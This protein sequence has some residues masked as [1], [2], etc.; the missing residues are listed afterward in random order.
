MIIV[1]F[2]RCLNIQPKAWRI[3]Y[4]QVSLKPN[5]NSSLLVSENGSFTVVED[6]HTLYVYKRKVEHIFLTLDKYKK[7]AQTERQDCTYKPGF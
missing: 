7:A 2:K 5:E 4:A 3:H 6:K 1:S